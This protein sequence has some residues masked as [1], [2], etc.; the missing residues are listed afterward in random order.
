ML[1][2]GHPALGAPAI[3][4]SSIRLRI[5][6][7]IVAIEERI[8]RQLDAILHHPRLLALEGTWR[9]LAWLVR[10][11]G[12][13]VV[14]K[15]L[16]ASWRE[17]ARDLDRAVEFDRSNLFR[18]VYEN[19]FG[20]PGGEPFGLLVVDREVR[21]R[22]APRRATD[23]GAPV[24]DVAVL[25]GLSAI[26]AAAF[27]PLVVAASPSLFGADDWQDLAL[28]ADI[29]APLNDAEHAR[30][31]AFAAREDARFVSVVLPRVL[32]RPR[33]TGFVDGRNGLRYD[34]R[35]PGGQERVWFAASYAFASCVARA[36][37]DHGWPADVR[38]VRTDRAGGGLV[39]DLPDDPF[40][41]GHTS[42]SRPTVSLGLT[43][44][45]EQ[46]LVQAGFMPLNSLPHGDAA[47]AAARSLQ[48]EPPLA[49]G[50]DTSPADANRHLSAQFNAVLCVSRFAHYVKVIA[51]D[52]VGSALTPERIQARLQKWLVGYMNSNP[53]SGE[54]ARAR[55]P[56]LSGRVSVHE[57]TGRPGHYGC[58]LHLQPHHQLDDV[59]T[60]F[61]LVTGFSA[62]AGEAAA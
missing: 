62:G 29:A 26:A 8:G 32:A 41:A 44:P 45:Q 56:L 10:G 39:P 17:L 47:F 49:P 22:P 25:G 30:W 35:A 55:Y 23:E 27:A 48:T 33:W 6:R 53:A 13:S 31:R 24:D 57:I 40:R 43:E 38:G 34:E 61:R 36:V 21:H 15:V 19:E 11:F 9:G 50:R 16:A 59:S 58:V 51:R 37:R 12:S 52:T 7:L 42:W 4:P 54:D 60:T 28:A 46:A 2:A 14:L 18:L 20:S 1:D 3:D 5:D